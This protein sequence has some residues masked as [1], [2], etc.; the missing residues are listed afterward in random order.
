MSVEPAH[1]SRFAEIFLIREYVQLAQCSTFTA[2][3]F[4][5]LL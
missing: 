1:I 4:K 2:A 5:R 3:D